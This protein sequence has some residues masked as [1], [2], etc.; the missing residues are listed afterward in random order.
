MTLSHS[1]R[2]YQK[3]ISSHFLNQQKENGLLST[4]WAFR[5]KE[6]LDKKGRGWARDAVINNFQIS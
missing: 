5:P 2:F 6:F 4:K 1:T 3:T